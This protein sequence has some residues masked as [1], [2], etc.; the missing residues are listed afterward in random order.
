MGHAHRQAGLDV[1]FDPARRREVQRHLGRRQLEEPLGRERLG[2]PHRGRR[3]RHRLH[4]VR[5][6][7]GRS[8][9]RRSRG[10]QPVRHQPRRG[11][12][13]HRASTCGT[14]RSCTTTSGT[15]TSPAR[16][17]SS[18][19]SRAAG[20]FPPSR[21]I[22]KIGL[23]FLLDRVTGKPIYGVEERPVPQSEVPLER[24]SKT[25]PFPLKPAPLSRMTMTRGGHR[26]GHAGARSGVQEAD[27]GRAAGRAVPA[28]RRT[29]ACACS[30]PATTAAS[31]G[32]ARRSIRSSATCSSTPTSWGSCRACR[33]AIRTRPGRRAATG[34]ATASIRTDRIEGVPGGGRFSIG[35]RLEHDVPAAAVGTADGRQRQHRRVRVARAARRHRQPA[36]RQAEDRTSRQR[37]HDRHR[38]RPRLRRRDRRQPLPRVRREDRQGAVDLQAGRRRARRRR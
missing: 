18:T 38:R 12:R 5:R 37:R 4:A 15:P 2:L 23:L 36:A 25:Q 34:R 3:A 19:S 8:V 35:R 28:G 1:P 7:V 17:R 21:S 20:R 24:A 29:T 9:R 6:A 27:R 14:S 30:S 13:E 22:N 33:I 32:A 10:R 31:T 16:R 11:R 26:D